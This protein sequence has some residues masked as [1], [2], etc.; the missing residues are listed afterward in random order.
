MTEPKQVEIDKI[1]DLELA[2][3]IAAQTTQL[4]QAQANVTALMA[5]L[6]KRKE[7]VKDELLP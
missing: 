2:E 1:S 5:E 4:Y 3:L 7:L 6:Q